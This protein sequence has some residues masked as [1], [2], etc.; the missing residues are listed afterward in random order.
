MTDPARLREGGSDLSPELSDLFRGAQKPEPLSAAADA[1]LR[2]QV[3]ALAMSP[4]APLF[5]AAPW[6]LAGGLVVVAGGL[7]WLTQHDERPRAPQ[8]PA[9]TSAKTAPVALVPAPVPTSEALPSPEAKH[10]PVAS[11]GRTTPTEPPSVSEDTLAVEAK[12][13]NQAHAAMPAD[14]RKALAIAGEHA[15]RYPRGQLAA[16]RELIVIQAL[17]KLG[18]THEAEA[19]G[20]ALRKSSPSSIY[21]ERLDTILKGK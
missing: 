6:L 2:G 20:R 1:R 8:R 21:G 12:L 14:P 5:K 18:R 9:A 3:S 19:R 10:A 17:V 7:A 16:E 13:L 4:P 15:K 11:V